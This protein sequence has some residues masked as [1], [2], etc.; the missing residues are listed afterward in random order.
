MCLLQ[1]FCLC[2]QNKLVAACVCAQKKEQGMPRIS[3]FP[4]NIHAVPAVCT[5]VPWTFQAPVCVLV[6]AQVCEQQLIQMSRQRKRCG[7][8]EVL[9]FICQTRKKS[10]CCITREAKAKKPVDTGRKFAWGD[11]CSGEVM[12]PAFASCSPSLQQLKSSG[13]WYGNTVFKQMPFKI[14]DKHQVKLH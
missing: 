8:R 7:S 9:S 4:S 14:R 5:S 11:A 10:H 12:T 13:S 6:N 3:V 1:L 2:F